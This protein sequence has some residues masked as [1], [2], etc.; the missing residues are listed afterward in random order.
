M[1]RVGLPAQPAKQR[2]ARSLATLRRSSSNLSPK[3]TLAVGAAAI[4][5]RLVSTS[6]AGF[7][8]HLLPRTAAD[9]GETTFGIAPMIARTIDRSLGHALPAALPSSTVLAWLSFAAAMMMLLRLAQA[10]VDGERADAAVLLSAV[11]P[12]AAIFGRSGAD[13]LFF[14]G[15]VAAFYGFRRQQWIAAGACGAVATAAIPTG[16]LILPALAWIGFRDAKAR[17][18]WMLAGL[19]LA[20]SG[21][22]GYLSYVYYLG[23]PAGGWITASREWGLHAEQAP[24]TPMLRLFTATLPAVDA[25]S[26]VIALMA[27]A[28]VPI[29]WWRLNGGY[30][31]YMIAM[32]S[33]PLMSGRYDSIGRICALLFPLF[34]LAA[35][36]RS[37]IIVTLIAVT[38][39]MFYALVIAM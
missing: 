27:L 21:L 17:V 3:Q 8:S 14:A 5:F 13:A 38:S 1:A 4:A 36:I 33:L 31:I 26:A 34:V 37:R 28:A 23:G 10:D 20:A 24:W 22:A 12:F 30:A 6:V 39:A 16:A 9:A 15:A 25:I 29:V 19:L 2:S 32:L 18:G 11:F 7:A 35:T